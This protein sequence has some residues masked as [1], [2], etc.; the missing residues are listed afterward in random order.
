MFN[1]YFYIAYCKLHKIAKKILRKEGIKTY[2]MVS[3]FPDNFS[4]KNGIQIDGPYLNELEIDE[5][6]LVEKNKLFPTENIV[7]NNT[8]L[9]LRDSYI[10]KENSNLVLG[11]DLNQAKEKWGAFIDASVIP[12][13]YK[14]GGLHNTA[15]ISDNIGEWALPSWIW[16]NAALVR[17]YCKI[18]NIEK[19][20][21]ITDLLLKQQLECGGWI[22]RNDYESEGPIPTLAP[23]DS[24][25]IANNAFVEMYKITNE[26]K[27]LDAAKKCANW[28]IKSARP[29]GLV[30]TGYNVKKQEWVKEK[31]IVDTGFTAGLFANLYTI[32]NENKYK[33]FLDN[34]VDQ[35]IKLFFIPFKNGFSTSIDKYDQQ[36]GGMFARG[37]A[38][39]LEGLIP[40]YKVL[41]KE[42]IKKVIELT[43]NNIIDKQLRNGGWSYNFAQPFLGEDC[44]GVS[45][46]AKNLLEWENIQ[47]NDKII[48]SAQK[49]L[50]W[51]L[52]HTSVQGVSKGGMFSFCM[53]GAVVHNFYTKTAFVYSSAYVIEM[54]DMLKER[55]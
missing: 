19:A 45:V 2:R 17:M 6:K 32:T 52:K 16:T 40:A 44:K 49:A 38:W 14:N 1:Y 20:I 10:K 13:E 37:Q 24:A 36:I 23:N 22:V 53:E 7:K 54:Y 46:I 30:W 50:S 29:D 27:Y 31:I 21:L 9:K 28:I 42:K 55:R 3:V 47:Q 4:A 8:N 41:K 51:C 5:Q 43:I 12:N 39:A 25:Y 34:F 48:I 18:G 35:Y 33:L 11:V 26:E 15:Y